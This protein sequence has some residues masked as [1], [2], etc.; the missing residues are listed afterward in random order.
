[1]KWLV[2]RL[3]S[4]Q[5]FLISGL[6]V[7]TLFT[8]RN[9]FAD[10]DIWCHLKVGQ[11]IVETRSLPSTDQ[12]SYTTN[13]HPWI[14]FEWLS[15]VLLYWTYQAGG[16]RALWVWM[17]GVASLVFALLYRLCA[18][19]SGNA[20]I[21]FVGGMVGWFFGTMGLG[22]RTHLLGY[23]F[24]VVELLLLHLGRTRSRAWLWG[25]PPLFA[26]WVNCHGTYTLGLVVMG[27]LTLCAFVDLKAGR[28]VGESWER[29]RRVRLVVILALSVA[30]LAV[31]PVGV[32]L[33][34]YPLQRFTEPTGTFGAV[35]DW[36]PL[37]VTDLRGAGL[38]VTAL[39]VAILLLVRPSLLRL[40][41]LLLMLL[42]FG[43]TLKY[44]RMSFALGILVAPVLCR[45][46]T[47]AWGSDG[48]EREHPVLNGLL[49]L[50]A[51]ALGAGFFP[52][53]RHLEQQVAAHNPGG[54]VEFI[55]RQGLQGSMLNDYDWGG[56]LIWEM[57]EKKV[58]IDTR[59]DVFDWTGVFSEYKAWIMLEEPPAKLLDKYGIRFCL[60]QRGQALTFVIPYLPGWRQVY[61]DE[62]SVI[63]ARGEAR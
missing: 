60:L 25:L 15:E 56:Y 35:K 10:P 40:E 1:M 12:F 18:L 8:V 46:L 41:E 44:S 38:F 19:Y 63:F 57:P 42:G 17:W 55:R 54:A 5:T 23:L 29:D 43:G 45:L 14:P 34:A 61:Q 4:F 48:P 62:L 9:R 30:A 37:V 28:L 58:F 53:A 47:E 11:V 33:L 2:R 22:L 21:A 36:Q 51:A 39:L 49:L 20:K 32:K 50:V 24:L 6:V 3:L 13:N 26:V 16:Y 59:A 27:I 52:T 31:N 7:L